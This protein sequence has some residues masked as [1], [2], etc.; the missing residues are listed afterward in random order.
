MNDIIKDTETIDKMFDVY[1]NQY[2]GK[3]NKKTYMK[4]LSEF[5]DITLDIFVF[6]LSDKP[7]GCGQGT[8]DRQESLSFW[9]KKC[10]IK[11][12]EINKYFYSVDNVHA[13]T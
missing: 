7:K 11:E 13:Y 4:N 12:D 1:K 2:Q 6:G 10:N 5:F 9:A 3:D 8:W